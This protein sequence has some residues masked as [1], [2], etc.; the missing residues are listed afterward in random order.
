VSSPPVRP[1][2][3][4]GLAALALAGCASASPARRPSRAEVWAVGDGAAQTRPARRVARLVRRSR[5]D[6]LLYL[7]DVYPSG[8][9]VDFRRVYHPLY[10][11]LARRTLPT[12]GNHDWPNAR[13]G[14]LPY[15][16][17]VLGHP[18]R[19]YYT[20]EA[21]EWRILSLNSELRG[22]AMRRQ[23]RWLRRRVSGPRRCRLAFWHTPRFS[24]GRHGDA[25]RLDPL[26][27]VVRGRVAL[28]LDGHDHGM[29]Q[30]EPRGGTTELVSGSGGESL[31]PLHHDSRLVFGNASIYGALKLVLRPGWASFAFVSARGRVL[32]RGAVGC[33]SAT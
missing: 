9:A 16:R 29:Q 7:G 12:P 15:W 27:R 28:V 30:L 10:G 19:S 6:R 14:Y 17:Q 20:A 25:R 33:D 18:I 24:A 22:P 23:V 31:Y 1:A 8:R 2:A 32:H 3:A 4:V 21:G 5:P 13:Q 26:W 11:A